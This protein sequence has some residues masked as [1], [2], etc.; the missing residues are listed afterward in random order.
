MIALLAA[1]A[2]TAARADSSYPAGLDAPTL[3]AWLGPAAD[4]APDQV[5]AVSPS[6]VTAVLAV[7]P[8]ARGT[9]QLLLRAEA[10]TPQAAARTGLLAWEMRL[11]VNCRSGLIRAG[12]T[13]G[14]ATRRPDSAPVSVAPAQ[15]DWS[16]PHPRTA[17][18]AAWRA[19]CD[20]G[21]KPPLA[22][23]L[24][25][26]TLAKAA[27]A[28]AAAV[29]PT[30]TT[31]LPAMAT[32]G[33]AAPNPRRNGPHAVQVASSPVEADTRRNL[34]GLRRRFGDELAGFET[35]IEPAQVRG[36]TVY[37]GLVAGFGGLDEARAYCQSLKRRGQDCL[38]K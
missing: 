28:P 10:V 35:R 27:P 34:D 16:R 18:E 26:A 8:D 6:A 31:A 7:S 33:P 25:V 5:V 15:L 29:R 2:T 9:A 11:E 3:S 14:Y 22:A 17:L 19:V 37:R 4:I 20:P 30:A 24:R 38:A 32:Q 21:F 13:S 12:S 23:R 1:L 36:R